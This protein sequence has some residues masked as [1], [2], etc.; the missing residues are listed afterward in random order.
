MVVPALVHLGEDL[1]EPE[2]LQE[3]DDRPRRVELAAE[4]G[5]LGR[6]RWV[7]RGGAG[8]KGRGRLERVWSSRIGLP[9][10]AV[11]S[12]LLIGAP[13]GTLLALAL[14]AARGRLLRDGR[15]RGGVGAVLAGVAAFGLFLFGG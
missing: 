5:E 10:V 4:G 15:K 9:G 1:D 14:G 6:G 2:P 11:M 13:L 8:S 7:R 3:P 12:P